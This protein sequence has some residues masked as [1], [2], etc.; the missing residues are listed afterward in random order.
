M[1]KLLLVGLVL[2]QSVTAPPPRIRN[3]TLPVTEVGTITYG[4]SVPADYDANNPRPLILALHPGGP[5]IA[6]YGSRFMEQVV[7][8]GLGDLGA[9]VIAPDCPAASWADPVADRVLVEVLEKV[10]EDYAVD[11]RR[12]LVT[13]FSM[14]GHGTWFMSSQHPEL[15]T[16]AIVMAAP[17]GD[18][19]LDRRGLIPTYV[20]HSRDDMVVP[21]A[22][23]ERA[24]AQLETLGRVVRFEDL[25]G[26]GHGDM[27]GYVDA[28][29][30][31][32]QWIA[33]NWDGK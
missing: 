23:A 3:R 13:G 24:T 7:L 6:Y 31:G 22:P 15:F 12:I 26:P 33:E 17:V 29:R 14:G 30:R 27:A 1:M 18:I 28:L 8:R 21:F 20:I 9:I 5:R 11:E 10:R 32:G 25:R 4:I 19:P 2:A 16:G